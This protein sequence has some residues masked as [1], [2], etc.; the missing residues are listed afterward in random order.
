VGFELL[1]EALLDR[2][3]RLLLAHPERCRAFQ[4]DNELLA[5]LVSR[6]ALAQITA[7]SLSG[8]FGRTVRDVAHG[9]VRE[10]LAHVVASDAHSVDRRPPSLLD[11]VEHEGYTEQA[12]WLVGHVPRAILDGSRVPVVPA[13][14]PRP[15]HP[16][17]RLLGH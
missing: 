2:G 7:S 13:V 12:A 17:K 16:L 14:P 1:L 15:R 8:G 11:E 4:R 9:L 6:G 3:H 5:R 10:G